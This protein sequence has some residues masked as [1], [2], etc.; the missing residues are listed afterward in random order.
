MFPNEINVLNHILKDFGLDAIELH[1]K[2]SKSQFTFFL[3]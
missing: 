3:K 1:I 2:L